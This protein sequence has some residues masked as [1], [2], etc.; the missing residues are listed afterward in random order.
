[1]NDEQ[2]EKNKKAALKL[3]A[4]M[5]AALGIPESAN[6]PSAVC[7]S[8]LAKPENRARIKA[9]VAEF[10]RLR[11]EGIGAGLHEFVWKSWKA[12]SWK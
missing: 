6:D 3:L 12:R 4:E 1:M 10:N 9:L 7:A 2:N 5:N 8:A 11:A